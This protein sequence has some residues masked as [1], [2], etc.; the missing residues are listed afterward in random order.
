M[1][2]LFD[3]VGLG[4]VID[5]DEL[6]ILELI[7]ALRSFTAIGYL[8]EVFTE[9]ECSYGIAVRILYCE[10]QVIEVFLSYVAG[11]RLCKCDVALCD[12]LLIRVNEFS[13]SDAALGNSNV[14]FLDR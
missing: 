4:S 12:D 8:L 3:S 2:C 5:F 7:C 13:R 14:L 1:Q 9:L 10:C 11:D 6:G